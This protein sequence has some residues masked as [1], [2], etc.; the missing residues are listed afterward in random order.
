MAD[1]PMRRVVA[2]RLAKSYGPTRALSGVDLTLEAGTVT[3]V[4]GPNGSGKST[5]LSLLAGLTRPTRGTLSYD[6]LPLAAARARIGVVTHAP[7][8]YPDLTGL[9]NL[10]LVA[11]LH[12]LGPEAVT[13]LRE[14]LA[15][16]AFLERPV[17]TYSRGQL[18]RT[19]LARALVPSPA[20]LLLDEPSTG[21]DAESTRLLLEVIEAHRAAGGLALVIS[22]DGGFV[23]ELAGPRIALR[24]GRVVEASA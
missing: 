14:R 13:P 12:S 16:G 3:V 15:L 20:L 1:E 11:A 19:S 9:E 23:S 5:L 22:H 6:G 18:Q 21:L 10:Q 24:D 7:M 2:E 17:R 8:L 4:L